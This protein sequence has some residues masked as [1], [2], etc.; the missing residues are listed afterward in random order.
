MPRS[1]FSQQEAA[2]FFRHARRILRH[3]AFDI[4]IAPRIAQTPKLMV[5]TPRRIGNAPDRNKA[6]RRI[7]ALFHEVQPLS[8]QYDCALVLKKPAIKLSYAELVT[9]ITTTFATYASSQN[10]S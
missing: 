2:L 8:D 7:K 1:S 6:R 10:P 5:V 3:P 9:L 4:L